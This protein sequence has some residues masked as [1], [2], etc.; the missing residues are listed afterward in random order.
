MRQFNLRSLSPRRRRL[1]WR[2]PSDFL[3]ARSRHRPRFDVMEDR[4]LLSTLLVNTTAD[5]GPG[6][7][8]QAILDSNADTAGTNSIDFAIPGQGAQTI[9]PASPLP[10]ITTAVLID[11]YSQE[12]AS[13]N[14]DAEGDNA[15]LQVILDGSEA[16]FARLG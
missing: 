6:S 8:R 9:V 1:D 13:P 16:G 7:L 3:H 14:S 11:G 12:G 2:S 10:T 4:T 15:V 5:D